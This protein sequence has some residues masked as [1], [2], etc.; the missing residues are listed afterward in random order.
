L[1][2]RDNAFGCSFPVEGCF[3]TD[4]ISILDL[5]AFALDNADKEDCMKQHS[6]RLIFG[7]IGAIIVGFG[8]VAGIVLGLRS[9]EGLGYEPGEWAANKTGPDSA[10]LS[11]STFPDS[12]A[13]HGDVGE[14]QI[15]WVTYCPSTSFKVPANSTIT[16]VIKNYDGATTL[17]NNYFQQVQG[18]I[19][20]VELVNNKPMKQVSA[21]KVA[22]TFTLQSTPDSPS[23]LFVSVPLVGVPDD[24]PTP[25]QIAGQSYPK[26]N[27]ISFQFHTGPP[28]T[29]I[30]HCY[31]PCG[32]D[33]EPPYGFTG[34]MSTTG[35]MAGTLTVANY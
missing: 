8:I 7:L 27:I 3:L 31:D 6:S 29:Y 22:H 13:C 18:T 4:L 5:L 16:V 19:G 14:P 35:W 11:I 17:V 33:R 2:N 15:E 10:T 12:Y 30:W 23:P 28:G 1:K 20:G 24:A 26:P 25:V 21:D 34:A 32:E 9:I